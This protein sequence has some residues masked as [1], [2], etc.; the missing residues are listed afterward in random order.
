[1]IF[2]ACLRI[3]VRKLSHA[4]ECQKWLQTESCLAVSI[5]QCITNDDTILKVL[6]HLLSF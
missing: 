6:K 1:M 5:N 2:T 3:L 4:T